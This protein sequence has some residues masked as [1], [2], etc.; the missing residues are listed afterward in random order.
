VSSWLGWLERQERWRQELEPPP[1]RGGFV[2]GSPLS[3]GYTIGSTALV[4]RLVWAV[5]TG[6]DWDGVPWLVEISGGIGTI[7][8][9][10]AVMAELALRG[11]AR[12]RR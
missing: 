4:V 12:R 10:A 6:W 5:A 1:E 2:L 11:V 8:M 3:A 9:F 7:L